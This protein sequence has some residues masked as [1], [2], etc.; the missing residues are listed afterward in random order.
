MALSLPL[1]PLWRKKS[2]E[3]GNVDLY[4]NIEQDIFLNFH[5]SLPFMKEF[6]EKVRSLCSKNHQSLRGN[7]L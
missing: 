3:D 5:P 7:K 4:Y 1:P 6:I 2:G